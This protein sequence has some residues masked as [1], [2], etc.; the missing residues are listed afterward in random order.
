ML[1]DEEL[2]VELRRELTGA[3]DIVWA[4]PAP[5]AVRVCALLQLAL[6]HPDIGPRYEPLARDLA[7]RLI[8]IGPAVA[9]IIAMG[10][11]PKNYQ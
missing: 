5:T 2:L 7:E 11:D 10:F 6:R 8:R 3:G 4:L 1:T 9:Q